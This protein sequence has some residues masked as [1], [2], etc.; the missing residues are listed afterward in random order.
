MQWCGRQ[1][2][3]ELSEELKRSEGKGGEEGWFEGVQGEEKTVV[4]R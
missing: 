1:E 2:R 4:L 3:G